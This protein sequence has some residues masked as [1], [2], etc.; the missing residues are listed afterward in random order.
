MVTEVSP[1]EVTTK[2]NGSDCDVVPAHDPT[3]LMLGPVEEEESPLQADS[4]NASI[5]AAEMA[6]MLSRFMKRSTKKRTPPLV[7]VAHGGV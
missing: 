6:R 4:V 2:L 5:A 3:G 7:P 1:A